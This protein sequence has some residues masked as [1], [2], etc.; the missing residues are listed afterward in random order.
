MNLRERLVE[1]TIAHVEGKIAYHKAN[2]EVYLT[3]PAGIGEHPDIIGALLSEM[4][5]IAEYQDILEVA[6][7][8]PRKVV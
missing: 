7:N 4:K 2:V 1:A 3:N 8:I 5:E 6:Q